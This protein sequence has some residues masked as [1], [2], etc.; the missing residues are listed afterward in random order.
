[1]CIRD[2]FSTTTNL[3]MSN[4]T[5]DT[6]N[7]RSGPSSVKFSAAE[8]SSTSLWRTTYPEPI[9]LS[10][11]GKYTKDNLG[12]AFWVYIDTTETDYV[13][14][15]QLASATNWGK[16]ATYNKW[17]NTLTTSTGKWSYVVIP[18]KD[19]TNFD[20]TNFCGFRIF[21]ADVYKRQLLRRSDQ[22]RAHTDNAV[23]IIHK[24]FRNTV[25]VFY[26]AVNAK[27]RFFYHR[28]RCV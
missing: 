12:L 5:L 23:L 25:R 10:V 28:S 18:L 16:A 26:H 14:T 22:P 8:G 11:D 2:S 1:M 9:D 13:Y 19:A 7:Y 27:N 20:I 21:Q 4:V 3:G 17:R 15:I 6:A 24:G